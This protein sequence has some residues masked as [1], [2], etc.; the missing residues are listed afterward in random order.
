MPHPA[1]QILIWISLS[2]S[3]QTLSAPGLLMMTVTLFAV[4]AKLDAPQLFTLIRRTRWILFSL[5]LVYAYATPGS[6]LVS[7]LGQYSPTREGWADGLM[8]LARLL[9]ILSGLAILLSLLTQSQFISGIHALAY[10]LSWFG[11]SRE[12]VAVRL[13]LT[14]RYAESSM[15]DTAADWRQAISNALQQPSAPGS[16]VI[17]DRVALKL[18]DGLGLL[19]CVTLLYGAWR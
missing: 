2:V 17:L 10:P 16:Q 19:L 13:A 5:L 15:R 11:G 14:L 8:Q 4:A 3:V 6:A 1:I 18:V 12:R 7:D 9:S